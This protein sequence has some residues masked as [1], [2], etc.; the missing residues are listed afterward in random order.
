MKWT[1]IFVNL[2]GLSR[3]ITTFDTKRKALDTVIGYKQIIRVDRTYFIY[4]SG[5]QR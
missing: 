5:D 1:V 4:K 3:N 2:R